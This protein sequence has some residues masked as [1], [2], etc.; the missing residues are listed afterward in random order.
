MSDAL[1]LWMVARQAPLSIGFSKQ[2]Y[3]SVLLY[4]PSGGPPYPGIE[5]SSLTSPAFSG[6]FFTASASWE[7]HPH[8]SHTYREG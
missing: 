5:P 4:P 3:W 7:A 2:E 6:E 1:R 8:L